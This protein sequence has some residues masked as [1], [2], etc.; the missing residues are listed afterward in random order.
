MPE[1]K[2]WIVEEQYVHFIIAYSEKIITKNLASLSAFLKK[3]KTTSLN[4]KAFV[5]SRAILTDPNH[6]ICYQILLM[7]DRIIFTVIKPLAFWQMALFKTLGWLN[8]KVKYKRSLFIKYCTNISFK[9]LRWGSV[10]LNIVE[11]IWIKW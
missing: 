4:R 9:R 7:A 2:R 11:I 1:F 5:C 8:A 10:Q 6:L 3:V